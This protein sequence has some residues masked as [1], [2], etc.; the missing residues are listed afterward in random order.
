V[1]FS[2]FHKGQ[3]NL[4]KG[5]ADISLK[6]PRKNMS[7]CTGNLDL[8]RRRSVVDG[9]PT[10]VARGGIGPTPPRAQ[11]LTP[12]RAQRRRVGWHIPPHEKDFL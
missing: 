8:L 5:L 11:D 3:Q 12:L 4:G 10:H 1:S 6:F 7:F 2:V 9:G